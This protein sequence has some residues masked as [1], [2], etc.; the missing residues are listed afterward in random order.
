[1]DDDFYGPASA[2]DEDA[3]SDTSDKENDTVVPGEESN[4]TDATDNT[5]DT[6]G[7]M[8]HS[9][10][11]TNPFDLIYSQP[12]KTTLSPQVMPPLNCHLTLLA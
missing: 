3:E 4:S 1:M 8:K 6:K 7:E 10:T 11:A 9:H 12:A 5:E 2:A